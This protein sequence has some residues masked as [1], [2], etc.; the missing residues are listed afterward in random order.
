MNEQNA[1][2][3]SEEVKAKYHP[4]E[5]TFTHKA[6]EVVQTLMDGAHGNAKLAL[7]RLVFYMNRAGEKLTN[8][9]ELEAAKEKL[10][11]LR[12]ADET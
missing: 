12:R 1:P 6:P 8:K 9:T 7:E 5:G 10:E 11:D 4:P 3:W 2:Y